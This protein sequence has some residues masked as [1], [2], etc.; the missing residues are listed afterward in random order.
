MTIT[1]ARMRL[2]QLMVDLDRLAAAEA[3]SRDVQALDDANELIERALRTLDRHARDRAQ[4]S[5]ERL[6]REQAARRS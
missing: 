4:R 3:H 6:R 2:A 1:D 5:L